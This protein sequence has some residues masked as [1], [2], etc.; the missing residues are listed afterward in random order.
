MDHFLPG[1]R[2]DVVVSKKFDDLLGMLG[3]I[4]FFSRR[5]YPCSWPPSL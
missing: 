1:L 3:A 5:R 4:V 2:F